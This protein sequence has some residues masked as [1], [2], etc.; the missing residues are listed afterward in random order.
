MWLSRYADRV[1]S[2]TIERT[3]DSF[4][5]T[6]FWAKACYTY[7][8]LFSRLIASI[9]GEE[10]EIMFFGQGTPTEGLKT[11]RD[12]MN[13]M[14][15][16]WVVQKKTLKDIFVTVLYRTTPNVQLVISQLI[17][18]ARRTFR[19]NFDTEEMRQ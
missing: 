17:A 8:Q 18:K 13:N 5:R 2:V 14:A 1:S 19:E 12:E 6:R 3:S 9:A 10:A 11:D 7:D 16:A 4:G 15:Q